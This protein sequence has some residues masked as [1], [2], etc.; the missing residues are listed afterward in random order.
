M[1]TKTTKQTT[2]FK[3]ENGAYAIDMQLNGMQMI[4]NKAFIAVD[5][6]FDNRSVPSHVLQDIGINSY[7]RMDDFD[8]D[9]FTTTDP[10]AENR[11][12]N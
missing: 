10:Y 11:Y 2:T 1:K 4:N 5:T 9:A 3:T 8:V 7:I 12:I 6:L